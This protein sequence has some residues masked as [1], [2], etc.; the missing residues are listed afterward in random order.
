[1]LKYRIDT[2]NVETGR[3]GGNVVLQLCKSIRSGHNYN[4]F[5]ANYFSNFAIVEGGGGEGFNMFEQ[6]KQTEV[7]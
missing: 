1:M 4:I 6:S 2:H 5:A 7:A 3:L